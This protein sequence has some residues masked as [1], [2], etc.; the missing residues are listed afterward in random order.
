MCVVF[1]VYTHMFTSQV[2]V[3]HM[4]MYMYKPEAGIRPALQSFSTLLIEA[5]FLTEPEVC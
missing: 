2:C 3:V 5:G 4:C 1:I